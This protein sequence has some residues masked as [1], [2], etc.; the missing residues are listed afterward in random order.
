MPVKAVP[1]GAGGWPSC[2]TGLARRQQGFDNSLKV[3]EMRRNSHLNGGNEA[4]Y[5]QAWLIGA[6][7]GLYGRADENLVS[8]VSDF[9][10]FVRGPLKNPPS[11][12]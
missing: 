7:N 6:Y 8:A 12:R 3:T 11:A 5:C 10:S 2:R 1:S 9:P 4:A